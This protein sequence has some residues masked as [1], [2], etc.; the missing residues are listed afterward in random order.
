[1]LQIGIGLCVVLTIL[2]LVVKERTSSRIVVLKRSLRNLQLK[3]NGL[4]DQ[5]ARVEELCRQLKDLVGSMK[6]KQSDVDRYCENM[7][8]TVSRLRRL[9]EEGPESED[10]KSEELF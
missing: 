5:N 8:E 1:M 2:G 3:Q 7:G 6:H 10:M 9:V 4:V